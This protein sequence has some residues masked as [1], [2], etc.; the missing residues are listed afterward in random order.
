MSL[1]EEWEN[2]KGEVTVLIL[3]GGIKA[4]LLRREVYIEEGLQS[5]RDRCLEMILE[6]MI[7]SISHKD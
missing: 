7:R 4:N 5:I 1:L 6:C 2:D 3:T